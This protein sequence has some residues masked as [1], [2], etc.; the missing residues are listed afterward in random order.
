MRHYID[1]EQHFELANLF[2]LENGNDVNV[3]INQNF[4]NEEHLLVLGQL[5]NQDQHEVAN[6]DDDI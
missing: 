1:E 4:G 6:D 5:I 3:I 2:D